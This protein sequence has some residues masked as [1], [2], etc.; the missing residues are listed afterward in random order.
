MEPA[1][2]LT[3]QR[4]LCSP[5]AVIHC[6]W[7]FGPATLSL[8]QLKVWWT[9]QWKERREEIL[10]HRQLSYPSSLRWAVD[11][12]R[13]FWTSAHKTNRCHSIQE[14]LIATRDLSSLWLLQKKGGSCREHDGPC[15]TE[16]KLKEIDFSI[17]CKSNLCTSFLRGDS[18]TF[19]KARFEQIIQAFRRQYR[20]NIGVGG[21]GGWARDKILSSFSFSLVNVSVCMWKGCICGHGVTAGE[22]KSIDLGNLEVGGW[23]RVT[24]LD[25]WLWAFVLF[26]SFRNVC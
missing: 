2:W 9:Y 14:A 11:T 19:C 5:Q 8:R 18:T 24:L 4:Q 23:A 17:S 12:T 22:F 3:S 16:V 26:F 7:V 13:P 20:I 21:H 6:G 25:F 10:F 15:V 1:F